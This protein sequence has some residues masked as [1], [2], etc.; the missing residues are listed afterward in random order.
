MFSM[1]G[2]LNRAKYLL[3]AFLIG[4]GAW[5]IMFAAGL[6]LGGAAVATA[7]PDGTASTATAAMGGT[8]LAVMVVVYFAM[9]VLI[10]F[11]AVK[12]LHDLDRPGS[13][14]W[15]L[16][17]PLYNLY[18]GLIL[19]FQKGTTGPNKYGPDPLGG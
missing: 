12:R 2:R 10:A 17:I 6:A 1:N 4:L 5:A 19:L 16:L 15:L 8:F 7:N 11:Q 3:Y 18:I 14:Y 9:L 13:H